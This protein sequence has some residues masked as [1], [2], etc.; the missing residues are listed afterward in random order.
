M[1]TSRRIGL[2]AVGV[3]SAA[4]GCGLAVAAGVSLPFTGDGNTITGCYSSG[5][6]LKVRTP[7]EPTCP[8][9]YQPISW[10]V[11]GPQGPAGPQGPQGPQGAQGPQGPAGT[12][13]S[14]QVRRVASGDVSIGVYGEADASVM[15]PAG[16]LVTGG[17]GDPLDATL[18][19]SIPEGN[20]WKVRASAG[21]FGGQVR[22]VAMCLTSS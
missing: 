15:C 14:L 22:A 19:W 6:A 7:S 12:I 16:S 20:G 11:T 13:A 10:G 4:I 9:G 21:I 3:A 8:K 18:V 17:G 1:R 5:G 2:I